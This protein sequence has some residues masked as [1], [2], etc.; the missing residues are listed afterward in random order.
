M[1]SWT[2]T[3]PPPLVH[4]E[5]PTGMLFQPQ[6]HAPSPPPSYA[7]GEEFFFVRRSMFYTARW[8]PLGSFVRLPE[9]SISLSLMVHG[10]FFTGLCVFQVLGIEWEIEECQRKP[11]TP[12]VA[13]PLC[14]CTHFDPV[15][16]RQDLASGLHRLQK[17]VDGHA[18]CLFAPTP[19]DLNLGAPLAFS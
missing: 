9:Y 15:R 10:F 5:V 12:L 16:M 14:C 8:V 17:V 4:P 2:S 13:A 3:P 1:H 18:V 11:A 6:W 19:R 7:K